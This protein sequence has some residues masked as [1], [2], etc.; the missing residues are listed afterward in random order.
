MIL[1]EA[2]LV[3]HSPSLFL[4]CTLGVTNLYNCIGRSSFAIFKVS[5]PI[6]NHILSVCVRGTATPDWVLD[7]NH[8]LLNRLAVM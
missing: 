1:A 6:V 4:L 3:R 2:V 5:T 8:Y 7:V